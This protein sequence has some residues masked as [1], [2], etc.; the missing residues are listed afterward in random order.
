[1]KFTSQPISQSDI[2]HASQLD[3]KWFGE[4]GISEEEL[5]SHISKH[6]QESMALFVNNNFEGFATFE[7]LESRLPTDYIGEIPPA[8]KVLF[9]QQFTTTTN[10]A[11]GDMTID[12]ALLSAIELKAKELECD[13][14]WEALATDHPYSKESNPK[15]DAFRF[16]ET[17]GYS[18]DENNLL[19]WK[20]DIIISI[21]CYLF[22]KKCTNSQLI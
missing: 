3:R 4:Y 20:P 10:Y 13:E 12:Q 17:N 6:P 21:P 16:Y 2:S 18:Y 7:I 8:S 14:V 22:R 1:M 5:S 19:T 15:H 11:K 9:I